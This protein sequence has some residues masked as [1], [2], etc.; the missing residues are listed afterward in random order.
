M[1]SIFICSHFPSCVCRVGGRIKDTYE[2]FKQNDVNAAACVTGKPL[3]QGGIRG[4]VEATGLGVYYGIRELLNKPEYMTKVGLTT[5]VKGKRVIVQGFG[6]V[7]SHAAKYFHA[8][9]AH[10]VAVVERDL[11]VTNPDGLDIPALIKYQQ[12]MKT[13]ANFPGSTTVTKNHLS[14]LELPCDVLLP[15]AMEQQIN[16][17]NAARIQ[18]KVLALD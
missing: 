8:N 16:G 15:C 2:Q 5:G 7:G 14:G 12:A 10:V 1:L 13:L 17:G 18:A 11:Y 6:N 3:E 4:R 9:G